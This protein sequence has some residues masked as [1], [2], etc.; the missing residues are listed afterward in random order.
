MN[1]FEAIDKLITEH[2]SASILK[3]HVSF[4][5]NKIDMLTS[6]NNV[7]KDEINSMKLNTTSLEKQIQGI[8]EDN[9]NLEINNSNL[10][11]QL[12]AV[13]GNNPDKHAC[14]HCG[15]ARLKRS[16]SRH[17][18]KKLAGITIKDALYTCDDCG[19]ESAFTIIPK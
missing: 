7:L 15:S 19:K 14:D 11:S 5:R 1:I 3:E 13:H 17:S 9:K 10:E 16:G 18:G 8:N 4:L 6:E 2:G 12:N